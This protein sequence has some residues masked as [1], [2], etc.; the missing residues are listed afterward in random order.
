VVKDNTGAVIPELMLRVRNSGNRIETNTS[1]DAQGI[2]VSP[3]LHPGDYTVRSKLLDSAKCVES[4]RLEVGQRVAADVTLAVGTT[5]ETIEVQASGELL[6][7]ESSS[8]SNLT[9]RGGGQESSFER[10]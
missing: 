2:Y 5:A 3:P 8:V 9:H 6:E 4:V 7:T 1:T 10:S